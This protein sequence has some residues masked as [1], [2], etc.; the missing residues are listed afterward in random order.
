MV[1]P[2]VK[3][4]PTASPGWDLLVEGNLLLR[5]RFLSSLPGWRSHGLL[6]SCKTA[7]TRGTSRKLHPG[8]PGEMQ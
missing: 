4:V 1:S 8:V 3:P 5:R 7:A 2:R 6:K